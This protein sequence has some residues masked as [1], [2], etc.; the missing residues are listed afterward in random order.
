MA[1]FKEGENCHVMEYIT[2]YRDLATVLKLRGGE[3]ESGAQIVVIVSDEDAIKTY[4]KRMKPVAE[5]Q[6][7]SQVLCQLRG[8]QLL[9]N[10]SKPAISITLDAKAEVLHVGDSVQVVSSSMELDGSFTVQSVVYEYGPGGRM[11]VEL[12]NRAITLSDILAAI[13]RQLE[14]R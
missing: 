4:G 5:S 7:T 13:E 3:D 6:W 2:D 10:Y 14:R 11:T 9:A 12:T 8:L 1:I